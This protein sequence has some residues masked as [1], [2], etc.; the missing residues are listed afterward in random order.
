MHCGKEKHLENRKSQESHTK[1]I[2]ISIP[3]PYFVAF[4]AISPTIGS[5]YIPPWYAL[6][7]RTIQRMNISNHRRI[8]SIKV[9][10]LHQNTNA[11]IHKRIFKGRKVITDCNA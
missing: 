9:I 4:S 10:P 3:G 5:L 2:P 8:L 6:I 11:K 7:M 1:F